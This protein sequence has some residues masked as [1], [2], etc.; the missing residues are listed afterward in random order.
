MGNFKAFMI[1]LAGSILFFSS[2]TGPTFER[3]EYRD[4]KGKH[5]IKSGGKQNEDIVDAVEIWVGQ[6]FG[7]GKQVL[8]V[9]NRKR[10]I[11]VFRFREPYNLMGNR[12][13]V[14]V[15]ATVKPV[16]KTTLAVE[17]SHAAKAG[18]CAWVS[19]EAFQTIRKSFARISLEIERAI[20]DF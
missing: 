7:S 19:Q 18:R 11:V 10:G 1:M 6:S 15:T 14:S 9:K 3:V 17:F 5:T 8:Q 16:N 4:V 12:C 13:N 20:S 2:C